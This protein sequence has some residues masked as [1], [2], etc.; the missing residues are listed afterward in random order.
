[1]PHLA[2]VG[3]GVVGAAIAYELS[4][5]PA[6]HL[7][8]LEQHQ[9][10]Q[11]STGAALG[12]LMGAISHKTKGRAWRMRETSLR[13]YDAWI[14]EL[15]RLTG[16]ALL[17]NRQGIV[18]LLSEGADL[19]NWDTLIS[20][21]RAQGWS[22]ACW[23]R[24]QLSDRCPQVQDDTIMAAIYSSG[25]RQLD[26][27]ALTLALLDAAQ[28]RG[29]ELKLETTVTAVD[30]A[31][32]GTA[33]VLHTTDGDLA[34]DGVV[35]AA[36][37]GSTTLTAAIAQPVD[38]RPVLGQ[39]MRVRLPEALG[40]PD[41]QPVL[42]GS[43]IHIVPLGDGDYWIGATVEFPDDI[44]ELQAH[45]TL[46][47]QVLE[48]AIAFC[49]GLSQAQVLQTWSGLRP[50]PFNRP[51]PIVEPLPGAANVWLA[52]GHYRNGVLLAPA[53]A[54]AIAAWVQEFFGLE[55]A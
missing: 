4:H 37:L 35:I 45:P 53:T 2:I 24:D 54:K 34:V 51:A 32:D 43:D 27:T 39:A 19:A 3:G 14:P 42:T 29:V 23:S 28:Q 16:K 21:R 11:A 13:C 5:I 38:I 40:H 52:S 31:A 30:C 15:E 12:V 17:Y 46:L 50:R 20:T 55:P 36:G 10:A 22:L 25:D 26:P 7:T 44:G 47:D 48:G 9:P 8:L 18:M 1:M 49:P 6:L 33:Q 41:F